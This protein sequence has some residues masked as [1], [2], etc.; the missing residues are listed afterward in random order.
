MKRET[1][2]AYEDGCA[3]QAE[4]P[5][6]VYAAK[7]LFI[8][9]FFLL[10][11]SAFYVGRRFSSKVL[12]EKLKVLKGERMKRVN[13]KILY[14]VILLL[15]VPK[16]AMAMHIMEG[17]LPIEWAIFWWAMTLPFLFLGYRSIRSK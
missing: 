8:T 1:V 7:F 11:R 13:W 17:F 3:D 6:L 4:W 14:F 5:I 15:L 10:E 16:R 2:S 9:H 12:S